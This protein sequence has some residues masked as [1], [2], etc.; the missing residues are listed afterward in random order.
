[1]FCQ[2]CGKQLEEGVKF[3][4]SCGAAVQNR[5]NIVRQERPAYQGQST[6]S[7]AKANVSPKSRLVAAL[8]AFFLGGIGAHRF[9]V[10]KNG[11][12]ILLLLSNILFFAGCLWAIVDF[13]IILCGSFTDSDGKVLANWDV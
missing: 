2:N 13:I 11:T 7:A 9:Y 1:M 6:S 5:E 3:C 8:L 12:G 10:G 4:D